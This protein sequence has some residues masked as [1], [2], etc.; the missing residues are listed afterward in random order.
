MAE[1][2]ASVVTLAGV[3]GTIAYYMKSFND[4]TGQLER[5][6]IVLQ[7]IERTA[8]FMSSLVGQKSENKPKSL[9]EL[10]VFLNGTNHNLI[11]FCTTNLNAILDDLKKLI[12][13]FKNAESTKDEKGF[14][15]KLD[16]MRRGKWL[17]WITKP[18]SKSAKTI[19][20]AIN[21]SYIKELVEAATH[22]ENS[23]Y[24]A[25]STVLLV[26][27]GLRQSD[28]ERVLQN[29]ADNLSRQTRAFADLQHDCQRRDMEVLR[30]IVPGTDAGHPA[31]EASS[32]NEQS[33]F[34]GTRRSDLQ[35]SRGLLP[36][37][38]NVDGGSYIEPS[39]P[40]G[41]T[42][43]II[44]N[45]GE[46]HFLSDAGSSQQ[47]LGMRPA[48]DGVREG[49]TGIKRKDNDHVTGEKST[50][51]A[52]P[53]ADCA[54]P[55][56][57]SVVGAEELP[58]EG[59]ESEGAI[60]S[61]LRSL[62]ASSELELASNDIF[63]IA[64][65]RIDLD[66][67]RQSELF[68]DPAVNAGGCGTTADNPRFCVKSLILQEDGSFRL[69]LR[70]PCDVGFGAC[71]HVTLISLCEIPLQGL[72]DVFSVSLH[73][74]PL[75]TSGDIAYPSQGRLR[76]TALREC[77]NQDSHTVIISHTGERK[78]FAIHTTLLV[79]SLSEPEEEDTQADLERYISPNF[80]DGRTRQA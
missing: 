11:S 13:T 30:A 21:E 7:S 5:Y 46:I 3:I 51:H 35:W 18:F 53:S 33:G 74:G 70:E 54:S 78:R 32:I 59:N 26:R 60:P 50:I 55:Q 68:I 49:D 42:V 14:Y 72:P 1:L 75:L 39:E 80:Q 65:E 23:L 25:L 44:R 56:A 43:A 38:V 15:E 37:E 4:T 8:G 73:Q 31:A 28:T 27:N 57:G 47:E 79:T 2:A 36:A 45:N 40:K 41:R 76:L 34:S 48:G 12:L 71:E 17:S 20:W 16:K 58:T 63:S 9:H 6:C 67:D 10:S 62:I 19:K 22:L 29:L 64:C 61:E 24:M 66:V 52:L 77:Q 69:I